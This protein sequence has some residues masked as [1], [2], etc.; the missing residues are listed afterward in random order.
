[1]LVGHYAVGFLGKRAAPHVPLPVL[2]MAALFPDFLTFILQLAG[3]EHAGLT[4]P[5]PRYFPLNAYDNPITHSLTM[6]VVWAGAC[7]AVY[8]MVRRDRRG[9][10]TVAAAVL[11][12]WVLD[13]V[14]HRPD[15]SLVPGVDLKVGLTLW[16]SVAGTFVVE[17][18]LWA[19]AVAAYVRA[20]R[21]TAPAG[22]YCLWLLVVS[23][24]M[25]FV[26]TPF[27]PTPA[28]DFSARVITVF[29]TVHLLVVS[30]AYVIDRHRVH[31][32]LR[33]EELG[34]L[35][36]TTTVAHLGRPSRP[37]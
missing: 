8:L 29:L 7:A 32:A 37:A 31:H 20:T 21:P 11:S 15:M 1:M 3:I 4:P 25:W 18:G 10:I 34:T 6:D 24:T 2:I 27:A 26:V 14:T 5:F 16:N 13:F 19:I 36:G 9:A 35:A 23:M 17:G 12:H 22:V 33:S 28:G 30:L